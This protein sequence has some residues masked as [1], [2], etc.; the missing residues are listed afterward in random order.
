MQKIPNAIFIGSNTSC[1]RT[2]AAAFVIDVGV[3]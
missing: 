2:L 1:F 3:F